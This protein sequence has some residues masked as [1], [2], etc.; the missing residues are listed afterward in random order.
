MCYKVLNW[1]CSTKCIQMFIFLLLLHPYQEWIIYKFCSSSLKVLRGVETSTEFYTCTTCYGVKIACRDKSLNL[2][3]STCRTV[4]TLSK[5]C[6]FWMFCVRCRITTEFKTQVL[7]DCG[8]KT[9]CYRQWRSSELKR[10]KLMWWTKLSSP[11]STLLQISWNEL[12]TVLC[13]STCWVMHCLNLLRFVE[14][15]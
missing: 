10:L 4:V 14:F 2:K 13:A 5:I 12:M 11:S 15:T 6:N 8:D 1:K 9:L 3:S 7:Q